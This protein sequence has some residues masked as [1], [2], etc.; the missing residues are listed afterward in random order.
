[1]PEMKDISFVI[2]GRNA[3]WS[4]GRLLESVVACAPS[5]V[6]SEIIYVDSA[7]TDGTLQRVSQYPVR[8]VRLAADR[9]LCAS[10]GRFVGSHYATGR[11]ITFLDSD[12]ELLGGWLERATRLLEGDP[13]IA[14]VSGIQVDTVADS[15][16]KGTATSYDMHL[17]DKLTEVK[18]AGSA[19]M[20]RRE[21]LKRVGTW[22]PYIVS[23][24]EPELCLRIRRAGYRIVRLEC[25]AVRHFGYAPPSISALLSRRKRRL[26]LGY[27]QVIRYHLPTGLLFTYLRERGWVV[28]PALV[29]LAGVIAL[30][31]SCLTGN[32]YWLVSFFCILLAAFA[33]DALRSRSL[34]KAMFHVLHRALILEGTIRGLLLHPYDPIDYPREAQVF[35]SAACQPKDTMVSA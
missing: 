31:V 32:V 9:G 22:N 26:F 10:A 14:V 15:P 8:I 7:S 13:G 34:Y 6:T 4:I 20:V 1:M 27:G 16:S 25:P 18:F 5:H 19:A 33:A 2:I 28:M 12:M 21:T 3:E 24:E 11:Y 29:G 30:L 23:D 17:K 35:D